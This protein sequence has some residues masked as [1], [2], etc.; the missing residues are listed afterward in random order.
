[1]NFRNTI[2]ILTAP[3]LVFSVLLFKLKKQKSKRR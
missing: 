2:F 1:M 3:L